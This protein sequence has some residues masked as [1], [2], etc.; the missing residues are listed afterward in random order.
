VAA[1]ER[2]SHLTRQLLAYAGKGRFIIEPVNLSVLVRE[3]NHLI[4]TSIPKNVQLRLDLTDE[5]PLV[6]ADAGQLQQVVMNLVINGAEAV[7]PGENGTV[8]V[9]TGVQ[10]VDE[11]Y[12]LST[13]GESFDLKP[14]VYVTLEVHDTGCGMDEAT[15]SRIFDPFFTTKFMGRGLGLAAVQGIVRGHKGTMKVYSRPGKGTTFKVLFPASVQTPGPK[16]PVALPPM[17]ANELVLV[18]DDEEI[19]RRTAKSM[20]ERHGYTVVVA[21]NGEQG[22]ELFKVLSEKVSAV[23]LDMTMPV[24]GGEEAF[25]RMRTIREDVRVIL[26]SGYNEVEAVRRFTGKGLAGFIQKPYSSLALA[27]KVRSVLERQS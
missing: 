8:L 14:G 7:T 25:S 1:S 11:Q 18:V 21:E 23:L 20:L 9:A 13:V 2:A 15:V 19:V 27:E 26:S 12:L 24:M 17:A 22:V 4:Q 3:I 5:L 16:R 6:D 10:T